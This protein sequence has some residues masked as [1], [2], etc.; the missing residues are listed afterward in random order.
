[1]NSYINKLNLIKFYIFIQNKLK[2]KKKNKYIYIIKKYKFA[3]K[4]FKNTKKK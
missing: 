4:K 1:M 2:I 3:K